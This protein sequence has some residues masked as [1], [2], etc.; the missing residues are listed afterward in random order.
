LEGLSWTH[1]RTLIYLDD[2]LKREFY[3]ILCRKEHW[4]TRTLRG[5]IDS[6]LY[7]RTAL[8]RFPQK[9]IAMH[10]KELN[11]KDKITPELVFRD[12]CVLDFLELKDTY[13][14]KDLESAILNAMGKFILEL[15]INA[16]AIE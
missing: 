11:S 9:T 2:K 5:R 1:I 14:E 12:P 6:M 16:K 4:N 10:L 7:E 15:L 13:S 8:S 3:S